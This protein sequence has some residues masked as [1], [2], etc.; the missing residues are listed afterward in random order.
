MLFLAAKFL[1]LK[2]ANPALKVS[3]IGDENHS[4]PAHMGFFEQSDFLSE[5]RL[6]KHGEMRVTYQ[7]AFFIGMILGSKTNMQRLGIWFKSTQM[8]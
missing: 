3:P 2:D 6:A 4:Y 5:T 7:F 1:E 8:R